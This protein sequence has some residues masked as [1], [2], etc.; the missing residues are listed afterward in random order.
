MP[1]NESAGLGG[2]LAD[3]ARLAVLVAGIGSVVLGVLIA[4]WPDKTERMA[5]L[6]FGLY[7]LSS[8][9][10]QLI[11]AIGARLGAALRMFVF[12]SGVTSLALAVMAFHSADS[13]LLL[14]VWIG[15]GWAVRGIAQATVAVWA[16]ELPEGGW[17]EIF[18]LLTVMV[19]F[20]MIALPFDS[21]NVLGM[22]AGGCAIVIGML[23]V[24]TVARGRGEVGAAGRIPVAPN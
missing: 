19:G 2:S 12:F 20:I 10:I 24:L 15:L 9:A 23:E 22:A 18:G 16:D 13:I 5:E 4:V 21:L 17:Q 1:E 6:L 8:G 14:A 3:G 11:I 7:L